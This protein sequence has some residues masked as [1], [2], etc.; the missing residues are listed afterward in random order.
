MK[1]KDFQAPVLFSSTFK[2]LNL[3]EK[4]QVLS[5]M[6]GNPV[7]TISRLQHN[8]KND[9]QDRQAIRAVQGGQH[10]L[11]C[12]SVH[13]IRAVQAFLDHQSFLLAQKH[14]TLHLSHACPA[15][16]ATTYN[17]LSNK[18]CKN[19]T[20]FYESV[21]LCLMAFSAY[22]NSSLSLLAFHSQ[23]FAHRYILSY[24]FLLLVSMQ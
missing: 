19:H 16:T 15:I 11:S 5:R 18:R 14:P 12:P 1:F 8:D 20:D 9:L 4:N 2:A 10:L 7:T 21:L 23:Q 22:N 17:V 3:G 24:Y 6:R 13:Q